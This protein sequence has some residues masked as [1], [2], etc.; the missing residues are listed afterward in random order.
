MNTYAVIASVLLTGGRH[1]ETFTARNA[2]DAAGSLREKPRLKLP[3][4]EGVTGALGEPS[5][6]FVDEKQVA[7]AFVKTL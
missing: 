7:S 4:F 6:A 1:V 2:T 3:E 5:F